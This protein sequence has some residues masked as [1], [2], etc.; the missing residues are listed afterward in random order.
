M[1]RIKERLALGERQ[2]KMLA[3][4]DQAQIDTLVDA[5]LAADRIFVTGW[6]RAGNNI[7]IMSMDC[8]QIG[9]A[10]HV[11][12]DNSTPSMNEKDLLVIG[13][14]SGETKSMVMFANQAK[15]HGSKIALIV[16]REKSTLG[17]LA[18]YVVFVP[19]CL[20]EGFEDLPEEAKV[21]QA[22]AF[23]PVMQTV[24][25]L[26]RGY[27]AEKLGVTRKDMHNNHNNIE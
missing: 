11:I 2:L 25:D 5:I 22:D 27:C 14:G 7:K 4:V 12:G 19:S 1:D 18:D 3:S 6:G 9:L 8:S 16:N 20:P 23:Y 24:C 26:V 17:E 21:V 15:S 13:S 10:T